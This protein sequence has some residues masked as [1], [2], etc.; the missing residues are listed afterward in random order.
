M[1]GCRN[2]CHKIR[3]IHIRIVT[4]Q[5]YWLALHGNLEGIIQLR[6]HDVILH[7]K[8]LYIF[9]VFKTI[10]ST[11]NLMRETRPNFSV[12]PHV[13][14][15]SIHACVWGFPDHVACIVACMCLWG[16]G[17]S[18]LMSSP[19]MPLFL[20]LKEFLFFSTPA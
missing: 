17:V 15:W 7:F 13:N 14:P 8:Y 18:C 20:Y 6:L 19:E 3:S 11:L 2:L 4:C 5:L 9:S 1:L 16:E 12:F 10:L